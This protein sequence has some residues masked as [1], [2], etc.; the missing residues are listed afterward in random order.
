MQHIHTCIHTYIHTYIHT[1]IHTYIHT[2]IQQHLIL[3]KKGTFLEKKGTKNFTSPYSIPFLS[4]LHQNKA[5]QGVLCSKPLGRFKVNSTFHPSEFDKVST[6]N[7]WEL[8]GKK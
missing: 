7:F 6:R 4:V 2:Y 3:A 8:S 1:C 5:N